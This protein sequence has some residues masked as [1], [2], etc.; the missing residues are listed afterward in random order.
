MLIICFQG[1]EGVDTIIVPIFLQIFYEKI[2]AI[3]CS[4]QI[5]DLVVEIIG[6]DVAV[7]MEGIGQSYDEVT[8]LGEEKGSKTPSSSSGKK[9]RFPTMVKVDHISFLNGKPFQDMSPLKQAKIEALEAQAAMFNAQ[10]RYYN[11]M[12]RKVYSH[13]D[14]PPTP[15]A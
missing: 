12:T 3:K 15:I 8:F 7:G 5:D 1:R 2:Q 6:K 14:P 11:A 13:F 9:R 4:F 10:T